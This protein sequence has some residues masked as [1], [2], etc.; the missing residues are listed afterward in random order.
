MVTTVS[1]GDGSGTASPI[2]VV[3]PYSTLR[4]NRSVVHD[5]I[6]GDI[7]V[8]VNAP[9][10]RSG[11]VAYLFDSAA[12]A[13]ACARMHMARTFFTLSAEVPE[14]SMSYVVAGAGV[15]VD[16]DTQT[17]TAWIVSVGFQEI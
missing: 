17:L 7:A 6:G 1:A 11:D 5:L 8:S 16:I 4:E 2:T 12:A 14:V 13:D 10:P 15:R 9:R 3:S